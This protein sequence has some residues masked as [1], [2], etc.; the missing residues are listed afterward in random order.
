MKRENKHVWTTLLLKEER[1]P[2]NHY[3]ISMGDRSRKTQQR[4]GCLDLKG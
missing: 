2:F 3:S 4:K 1:G